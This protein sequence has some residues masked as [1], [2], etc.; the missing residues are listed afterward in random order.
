MCIIFYNRLG[1]PTQ[2]SE[3]NIQ[4]QCCQH[5]SIDWLPKEPKVQFF[6]WWFHLLMF[7]STPGAMQ[8]VSTQGPAEQPAPTCCRCF[9]P[10]PDRTICQDNERSLSGL[11][12]RKF[13]MFL[14]RAEDYWVSVPP[15]TDPG[16]IQAWV[17]ADLLWTSFWDRHLGVQHSQGGRASGYMVARMILCPQQTFPVKS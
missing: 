2:G 9:R 11:L 8:L 12:R 16:G 17:C 7:P 1:N 10:L 6:T 5:R 3:Q 4:H 13:Q 14:Y 15:S